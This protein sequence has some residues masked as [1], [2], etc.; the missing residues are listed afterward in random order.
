MGLLYEYHVVALIVFSVI[1]QLGAIPLFLL[2]SREV[3]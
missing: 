1:V 3:G 2:I